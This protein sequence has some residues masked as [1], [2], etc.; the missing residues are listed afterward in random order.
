MD[1][2]FSDN[3]SID[4][5]YQEARE[6]VLKQYGHFFSP[7]EVAKMVDEEKTAMLEERSK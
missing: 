4:E 7:E 5:L 1:N 2:C 6:N 3:R